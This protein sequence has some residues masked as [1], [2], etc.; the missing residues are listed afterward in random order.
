[1]MTSELKRLRR[2]L[3]QHPELSG[4]EYMTAE[5][6]KDYLA[7]TNPDKIINGIGGTGLAAV[8]DS[9][10]P[11]LTVLFRSELDALPI[12]E[13]NKMP[14]KSSF[15]GVSHKCGHDGHMTMIAG[16]ASYIGKNRPKTGR[17][18]I[19]YQPAEET[20]E[21]AAWVVKD[22]SFK[23]I[24]PDYAFALHNL[25]GF[26][27]NTIVMRDGTFASA[28]KG[29]IA[30]LHGKTSHAGEPENG[31]NPAL[32][33]AEIIKELDILSYNKEFF[34]SLT[35]LTF[36]HFR[37]GE[38]AFGTSAGYAEMMTT[39]RSYSNDDMNSLSGKAEVLIKKIAKKE[40]LK[41]SFEWVE[42]F[43]AV[44]NDDECNKLIANT[45]SELHKQI[46]WRKEPFRWSEDFSHFTNNYKGALFGLGS[47]LEQ[48]QLH[49]PD[50]DFPEDIIQT[51]IEMFS[52]IY[53]KLLRNIS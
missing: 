43:L 14:Y 38:R 28:S 37:L 12:Q 34:K 27:K 30:K 8:Y 20:G 22:A 48:P 44:V 1:M 24:E 52:G 33:I 49:N 11:G 7:A 21:G 26:E 47:G 17:A 40:K 50:Y 2:A 42:E 18:V 29:M 15:D 46:N 23:T 9:G 25:P 39:L 13:I 3:H 31:I 45:A 51:G 41:V 35:F 53:N 36:I 6:I 32:A 19:M 4:R 5:R 10:L 16:L